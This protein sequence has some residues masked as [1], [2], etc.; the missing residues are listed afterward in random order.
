M[1]NLVLHCSSFASMS[2]LNGVH[3][4]DGD[5]NDDEEKDDDLE[6]K[7]V[8]RVSQVADEDEIIAPVTKG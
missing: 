2:P 5:D 8:L 6:S 4:E 1:S 7:D 3:D